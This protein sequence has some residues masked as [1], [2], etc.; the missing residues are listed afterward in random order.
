ML[1]LEHV[2]AGYGDTTILGDVSMVVGRGEA[3]ALLGRNGMGKTTTLLA[4]IGLNPAR[5]GRIVFKD[6]DTTRLPPHAI[7]RLG[8]GYVPEGRQ[9][10]APLSVVQN[11]RIPFVNKHP[12]RSQWRAQLERIFELFPVLRERSRQV[13]GSLSGGE[14]QMVA[15][16]RALMGGDDLLVLDEP[17]EGL[18]PT[19]VEVI[20]GALQR[21]KAQGLTVLLVEQNTHTAFALADRVYVLEKGRVAF[22]GATDALRTDGAL[23]ERYLGV[24]GELRTDE[25]ASAPS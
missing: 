19:A 20:V 13:A 8:I 12:H 3:V 5:S 10:F 4:I 11:L 15:I 18:A 23:L 2:A 14:Q 17:T 25:R 16:A 22:E 21:L 24:G 1:R 9:L 7:A 6:R